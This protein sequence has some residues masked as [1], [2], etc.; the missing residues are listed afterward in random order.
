MA[1]PPFDKALRIN[2]KRIVQALSGS[3]TDTVLF[4]ANDNDR[5]YRVKIEWIV[6]DDGDLTKANTGGRHASIRGSGTTAVIN[7]QAALYTSASAGSTG[8]IVFN[9]SGT[10]VRANF[11]NDGGITGEIEYV[12][13]VYT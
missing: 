12:L 3:A 6:R 13:T 1:A 4:A 2:K 9:I 5:F 7:A 10:N 8:V 11:S